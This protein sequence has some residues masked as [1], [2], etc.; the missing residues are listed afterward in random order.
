MYCRNLKLKIILFLAF[1]GIVAYLLLPVFNHY[2]GKDD[3]KG[4]SKA[5]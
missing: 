3:E 5:K 1:L 4:D 2:F